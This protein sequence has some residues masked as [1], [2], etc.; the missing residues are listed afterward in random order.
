MSER[1]YRLFL[2]DILDSISKIESYTTGVDFKKFRVNNMLIDAVIRNFEI[3]G[4]AASNVPETI[5]DKYSKIPWSK[6][7]AMRN[8]VIHEYFGVDLSIT[9]KTAKKSL[10]KLKKQ[11]EQA[12]EREKGDEA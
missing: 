2:R 1:N 9:W 3:I 6:M 5:Q 11:I 10:P 8:L 12:M 4:E 7:K